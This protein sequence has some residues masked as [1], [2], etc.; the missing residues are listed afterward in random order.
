MA[1]LEFSSRSPL[2][3]LSLEVNSWPFEAAFHRAMRA[4]ED[5]QKLAAQEPPSAF[6]RALFDPPFPGSMTKKSDGARRF[7]P[8]IHIVAHSV[9]CSHVRQRDHERAFFDPPLPGSKTK[10]SDG[11][12]CFVLSIH[13]VAHS[14]NCSHVR[15]RDQER[16]VRGRCTSLSYT[17]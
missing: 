12:R 8:S 17:L 2:N 3:Q 16:A 11:T 5:R 14:V 6:P 1:T 9:D 13:I 4:Y 7:V 15:R 10:K